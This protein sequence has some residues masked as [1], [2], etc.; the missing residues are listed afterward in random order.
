MPKRKRKKAGSEAFDVLK[1]YTDEQIGDI[2]EAVDAAWDSH[3]PVIRARQ[4]AL[5]PGGKPDAAEFIR[6]MADQVKKSEKD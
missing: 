2:Q 1:G 6:V 3:D 4:R 5:F